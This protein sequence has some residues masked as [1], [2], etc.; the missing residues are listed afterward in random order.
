M[1]L[2]RKIAKRGFTSRAHKFYQ[3]INLNQLKGIKE[4]TLNPETLR[5]RGLIKDAGGLVKILGEGEIKK[6]HTFCVHAVSEGAAE[7]IRN[8]GGKVEIINV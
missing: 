1:P 2:I 6:A 4:D 7:K 5:K 3:I 8:S